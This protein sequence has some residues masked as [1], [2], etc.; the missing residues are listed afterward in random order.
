TYGRPAQPSAYEEDED[1][2]AEPIDPRASSDW[3]E[4]DRE[5]G[6][7]PAPNAYPTDFDRPPARGGANG[8]GIY[9]RPVGDRDDADDALGDPFRRR[10]ARADE[11]ASDFPD[12]GYPDAGHPDAG[13]PDAG[14]PGAGEPPAAPAQWPPD[15]PPVRSPGLY[16]QPASPAAPGPQPLY[17]G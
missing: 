1:R 8:P 6:S 11:P 5:Y 12:A 17:G 4:P 2:G 9:G 3:P 7:A 16:G 10:G 13:Y 15:E 14:F